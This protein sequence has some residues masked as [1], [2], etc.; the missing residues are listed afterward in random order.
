MT[1][2]I[3][4][5][6]NTLILSLALFLASICFL[7]Y[8]NKKVIS[9]KLNVSYQIAVF[10][11]FLI[12]RGCVAG[13]FLSDEKVGEL[14]FSFLTLTVFWIDYFV[15]CFLKSKHVCR[16]CKSV[17][18]DGATVCARCGREQKTKTIPCPHCSR[19]L[20]RSVLEDGELT[21]CPYCGGEFSVD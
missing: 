8:R 4:N 17:L 1:Y 13:C 16:F 15:L 20:D 6:L 5:I 18:N 12:L 14:F 3:Y 2:A 11:G 7:L 19:L 10:V 21:A 9:T